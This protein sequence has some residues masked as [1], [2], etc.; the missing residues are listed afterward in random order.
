ME[1]SSR[2]KEVLH[3]IAYEHTTAE[4]A[5][6]LYISLDTVKTHRRHLLDKMGARNV[7]G[8]IRRA[9]ETGLFPNPE[10]AVA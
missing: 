8:L 7:A 9:Y 5:A 3:M 1:I 6:Q 10:L 4:I 2:E